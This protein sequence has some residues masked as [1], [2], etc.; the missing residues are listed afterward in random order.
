MHSSGV[1]AKVTLS[2]AARTSDVNDTAVPVALH[3]DLDVVLEEEP[4]PIDGR[5]PTRVRFGRH[6]NGAK[7]VEGPK[8]GGIESVGGNAERDGGSLTVWG[9]GALRQRIGRRGGRRGR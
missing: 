1:D 3:G 6:L 8:N 4:D 7:R 9:V 5:R 2:H